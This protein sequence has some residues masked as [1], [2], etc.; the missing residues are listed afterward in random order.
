MQLTRRGK[1]GPAR[2][3]WMLGGP[4][5]LLGCVMVETASSWAQP[6]GGGG[7]RTGHA[8]AAIMGL[9]RL[10]GGNDMLPVR[11]EPPHLLVCWQWR[12]NQG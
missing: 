7:A 10:R 12:E 6:H 2:V 1:R 11:R 8:R 3:S 9:Q 4:C 5:L